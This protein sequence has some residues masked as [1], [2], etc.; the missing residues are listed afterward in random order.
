MNALLSITRF[1]GMAIFY[2]T[3][4]AG[5]ILSSIYYFTNHSALSLEAIDLMR[6]NEKVQYY[7]GDDIEK[8]GW[9]GQMSYE[10]EDQESVNRAIF[11]LTG[12]KGSGYVDIV[13]HKDRKKSIFIESLCLKLDNNPQQIELIKPKVKTIS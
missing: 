3:C 9:F 4:I 11:Y 6:G 2:F 8:T 1:F 5:L 7:L 13:Y 10:Q 12:S